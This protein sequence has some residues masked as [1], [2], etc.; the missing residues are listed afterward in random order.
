MRCR[1]SGC[2]F[3]LF[4]SGIWQP[5]FLLYGVIRLPRS[6]LPKL[7]TS[8]VSLLKR[9]CAMPSGGFF[10]HTPE[11]PIE[12]FSIPT[13]QMIAQ[14]QE[15]GYRSLITFNM[16]SA[17]RLSNRKSEKRLDPSSDSSTA[18]LTNVSSRIV[19]LGSLEAAAFR[20]VR[21]CQTKLW[22]TLIGRAVKLRASCEGWTHKTSGCATCAKRRL[23]A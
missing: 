15:H 6:I 22:N 9:N 2:D 11:Q 12:K 4:R 17:S 18:H 16:S 1:W 13:D 23:R 7:S 21:R 19:K 20:F 8:M 14:T 3:L 5:L 10:V